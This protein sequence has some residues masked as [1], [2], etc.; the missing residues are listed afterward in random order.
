MEMV[1]HINSHA[2]AEPVVGVSTCVY[3]STQSLTTPRLRMEMLRS[4]LLRTVLDSLNFILLAVQ[5]YLC[6]RA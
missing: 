1:S 5:S 3:G 2:V 4:A 6:N